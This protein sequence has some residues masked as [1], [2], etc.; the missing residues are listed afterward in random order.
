M[1]RTN[2]ITLGVCGLAVAALMS[3]CVVS[4]YGGVDVYAPAP[5]VTVGVYPDDYYWDGYEYVGIAGGAYFYL[6]PGNVWVRCEPWRVERFEGWE[7]GHPDWREHAVHNERYRQGG[8]GHDYDH[9]RDRDQ[10]HDQNRG[11]GHDHD[12]GR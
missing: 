9:S 4:P 6:G 3:G 12:N 7:R 11:H 1:N 8:G 5:A 2:K 10:G